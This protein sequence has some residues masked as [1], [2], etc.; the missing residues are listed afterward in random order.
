VG[1]DNKKSMWV[2]AVVLILMAGTGYLLSAVYARNFVP[3]A[4]ALA[5]ADAGP[6]RNGPVGAPTHEQVLQLHEKLRNKFGVNARGLPRVTHLDYDGWPDRMHVVV[7]LDHSPLTMTPAQAAE[8]N[9]LLDVVGAVRDGGLQWRWI[10]VSATAPMEGPGHKVAEETVVR[11]VFSRVKLDK[12]DWSRLTAAELT[13]MAE[14]FNVDPSI[15]DVG[16]AAAPKESARPAT[17][18]APALENEADAEAQSSKTLK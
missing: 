16:K 15:A 12:A 5:D 3:A 10:L 2:Q 11:A 8:L 1:S 9:P 6:V 14:Q 4:D 17:A 7:A 18:P 13:A